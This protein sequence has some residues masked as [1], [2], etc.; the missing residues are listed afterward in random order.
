M[1]RSGGIATASRTPTCDMAAKGERPVAGYIRVS[2]IGGRSG[3]GYI[4]PDD[5]RKQI[6]NYAQELGVR[7][8]P[9]AWG[10]DQDYSGGNF[11][12]PGWESIVKRIEAGELAGVIVLR[13]DRFARNVP[14]G[15]AQIRHIVDECQGIFG[16]AQERM[17]PAT[18]AGRYMLQ[19]FLNNAE[20]QLNMLKGSWK[21]AK[22]LAIKRGAHI[23]PTPL[24]F[25]RIPKGE[26]RSG[27]LFPLPDWK[28]IITAIFRRAA[29]VKSG[30]KV[31]AN[32]M[33]E[34]YPRPDG[35]RWT[36]TTVGHVIANRVYL[37]EVAYRPR[38]E[39]FVPLVNTE[40]H[41]PM[42][43]EATWLAAQRTPGTKR[44][45][46]GRINLLSGLIR[47]AGCRY[48]M[49]AS[50]GGGNLRVYRCIGDH[51]GGKCP[52]P[53][54]IECERVEQF[55]LGEVQD[56]WEARF[57]VTLQKV[58]GAE[59]ADEIAAR[60][61][62]A[63]G[64]LEAFANDLSARRLLGGGYHLALETR[65]NAVSA[66]EAEWSAL[67]ARQGRAA[68]SEISWDSLDR[69]ELREVLAGALDAVYVRRG[70][71]MV[72]EDRACLVW[73]GEL[74]DDVPARG[75]AAT[76]FRP[77]EWPEKDRASVGIAAA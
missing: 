65:A 12:R 15:A 46:A 76:V 14:D 11:N 16:S 45:N 38:K 3:E 26:Q 19:Q 54:V 67:D 17:D 18:P 57:A 8:A 6:E 56:Q 24:G 41:E 29:S 40:A 32:F 59:D 5:Q 63:R 73:A 49:S 66:I 1:A 21:T 2:R 10:D 43:D 60:L 50:R 23:G 44:T 68:A 4:S 74:D 20:L 35:R 69:G 64:E 22:E 62:E 30:N 75:K 31:L 28:P 48:R 9:D 37:G 33:N 58:G 36:A 13:V 61:A 42:V 51:G 53:A 7:I 27:C 71:N 52:A 39:D 25:G 77:F 55:A 47:C 72:V 70:R 34:H